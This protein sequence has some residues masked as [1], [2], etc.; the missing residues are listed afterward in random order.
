MPPKNKKDEKKVDPDTTKIREESDDD[1]SSLSGKTAMTSQTQ[2]RRNALN[3]V[4]FN[5]LDNDQSCDVQVALKAIFANLF[6]T[7]KENRL[8][9]IDQICGDAEFFVGPRGGIINIH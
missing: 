4:M 3:E 1:T 9:L 8:D 6:S 5:S 2:Q 7:A